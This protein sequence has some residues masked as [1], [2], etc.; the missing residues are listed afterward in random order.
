VRADLSPLSHLPPFEE[1]LSEQIERHPCS[2]SFRASLKI[3]RESHKAILEAEMML[4]DIP[5]LRG[6]AFWLF[7]SFGID[8]E[9]AS[10]LILAYEEA[11]ANSL[12]H[13]YRGSLPA[14]VASE[15]AWDEETLTITLRDRGE[16]GRDPA[17]AQK[18]E[19]V[20]KEGRPPL[21]HR[22]GLGLYLMRRLMDE[23]HYAMNEEE[24]CLVMCKTF[25]DSIDPSEKRST[26]P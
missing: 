10:D 7:R 25:S 1:Y 19:Q 12:R 8:E 17:L 23:L 14:W 6:L 16:G 5:L 11:L 15:L 3:K 24:N 4:S 26:T 18:I 9:G 21:R 13:A 20:S 2:E 22:G